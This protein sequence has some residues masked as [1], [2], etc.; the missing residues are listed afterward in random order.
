MIMFLSNSKTQDAAGHVCDHPFPL[1]I[2]EHQRF[3]SVQRRRECADPFFDLAAKQG[4]RFSRPPS[5][6]RSSSL[7]GEYA[8]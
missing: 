2:R 4:D 7:D 8:D 1:C 6:S 5:V 3:Q